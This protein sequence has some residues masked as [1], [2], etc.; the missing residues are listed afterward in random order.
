ML[1][2]ARYIDYNCLSNRYLCDDRAPFLLNIYSN[3]LVI[4]GTSYILFHTCSA[5]IHIYYKLQA[6]DVVLASPLLF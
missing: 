4:S 2:I 3:L 6:K 1:T 5:D